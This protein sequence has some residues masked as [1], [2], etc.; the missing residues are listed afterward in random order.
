M[1]Q[2]VNRSTP[3]MNAK[4]IFPYHWSGAS[5]YEQ[6]LTAEEREH[7]RRCAL[8]GEEK[9]L[10][11]AKYSGGCISFLCEDCAVDYVL[12][13]E[14]VK[15]KYEMPSLV[16]DKMA[17]F[18]ITAPA[19]ILEAIRTGIEALWKGVVIEVINAP[20]CKEEA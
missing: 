12:K 15:E 7:H 19:S 13:A 8:C 17:V 1:L 9:P 5:L 4:P 20:R 6:E 2:K 10:T 11:H 14:S 3:N 18:Q 16:S